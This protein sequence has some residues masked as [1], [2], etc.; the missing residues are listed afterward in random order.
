MLGAIRRVI[1]GE[2]VAEKA[3]QE[4]RFAEEVAMPETPQGMALNNNQSTAHHAAGPALVEND[5]DME[6]MEEKLSHLDD[7]AYS[8]N[9]STPGSSL[10]DMSESHPGHQHEEQDMTGGNQQMNIDDDMM[11]DRSNPSPE[12]AVATFEQGTLQRNHSTASDFSSGSMTRANSQTTSQNGSRDW[13]WFE[14]VHVSETLATPYL[15]RKE[16]TEDKTN[17]KKGKK[18]SGL[19]PHGSERTPSEGL[20]EIVRSSSLDNGRLTS[21]SLFCR[22]SSRMWPF[23]RFFVWYCSLKRR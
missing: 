15:K 10:S 17:Q 7:A 1:S 4:E 19:A 9:I 21:M 14:D 8:K 22:Y 11:H 6:F 12:R 16:T 2:D 3:C 13:G 23:V 18:G 5:H 20:R